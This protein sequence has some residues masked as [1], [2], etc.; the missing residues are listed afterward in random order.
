LNKR[1]SLP[2]IAAQTQPAGNPKN[3]PNQAAATVCRSSPFIRNLQNITCLYFTRK[4]ENLPQNLLL[5]FDSSC[6]RHVLSWNGQKVSNI[7]Y[8]IVGNYAHIDGTS[9]PCGLCT[10]VLRTALPFASLSAPR[11]IARRK[12]I[13]LNGNALRNAI[14]ALDK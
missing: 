13:A 4:Q 5:I 12:K 7:F 14:F 6:F 9:E 8:T 2:K 11:K 10:S 1:H 3:F